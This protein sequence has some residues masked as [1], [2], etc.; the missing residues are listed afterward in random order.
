MQILKERKKQEAKELFKTCDDFTNFLKT[1]NNKINIENELV[2]KK[3]GLIY[4]NMLTQEGVIQWIR[5]DRWL[6]SQ[7]GF[8]KSNLLTLDFWLERGWSEEY[9]KNK[10][11]EI[12]KERAIL[13]V[14]TKTINKKKIEIIGETKIKFKGVKFTANSH[15]MC[16]ICHSKLTLIKKNRKNML[17][18]VYYEITG[19]SNESCETKKYS[20]SDLYKSYLPKDIAEDKLKELNEIISKSNKLC[21]NSWVNKGYSE[22]EAKNK[23][24]E[25]QSK[26]SLMVKNRFIVSKNKLEEL[27]Y[28]K[29]EIK[30][31]CQTP[32]QT[33][34]WVSK[35]Y[36]E[37]ESIKMVK[38]NQLN[39]LKH[40]DYKNRLLPSNIDYWVER[41]YTYHQAKEKVIERQT[42]FSSDICI[43]KY[44]VID[45]LNRFNK[46][47]IKWLT[48]YKRTNFS[49]ISQQLFWGIIESDPTIK[50]YNIYFATYNNGVI[51]NSGKNNEFRLKLLNGVIL[52]DFF[53]EVSKKI[54]EFD[55]TYYHRIT[56]ENSLREH[57]RDKMIIESGYQVLHVS[58]LDYKNSKQ[59]IIDKCINFLKTK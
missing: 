40:F 52:P 2:R 43:K 47:Q 38:T 30:K 28:S 57:K 39:A 20:K 51:D 23:I 24:S 58:E 33:N 50:N 19:C 46:R 18:S 27:G 12:T 21:V 13:G 36:S 45:G 1:I 55:G 16:N 17:N 9:S 44:G 37:E 6:P 10:I 26:Y 48:N 3:I 4:K 54:I 49:K 42:T 8:K 53:D 25:I 7:F 41:G 5:F 11:S 29:E 59:K 56:P 35:G 34:F 31:I 14:K 32:S 15:P 22:S